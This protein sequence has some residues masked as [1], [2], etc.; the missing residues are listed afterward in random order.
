LVAFSPEA[1]RRA[2]VRQRLTQDEL[3]AVV[4]CNPWTVR[5]WEQGKRQPSDESL[6][7]LAYK[8]HVQ[9]H[10]LTDDAAEPVPAA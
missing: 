8:L 2:R 5:A 4:H 7:R 3:A 1:L 6:L 9:P 10:E